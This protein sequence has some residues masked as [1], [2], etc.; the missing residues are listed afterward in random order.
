MVVSGARLSGP[1]R[2]PVVDAQEE[3]RLPQPAIVQ[4]DQDGE[5]PFTAE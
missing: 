1:N 4:A 5:T 3:E 2:Y